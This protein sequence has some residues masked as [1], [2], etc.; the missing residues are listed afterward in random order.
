V[1]IT[2]RRLSSHLTKDYHSEFLAI[3]RRQASNDEAHPFHPVVALLQYVGTGLII[4]NY[5][6]KP[7]K[8]R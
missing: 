1:L 4:L 6:A 2:A 7:E 5:L 8:N 3:G